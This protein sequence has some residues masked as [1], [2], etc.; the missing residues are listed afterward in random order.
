M[1]ND[2]LEAAVRICEAYIEKVDP[3]QLMGDIPVNSNS[4]A[5]AVGQ[6]LGEMVDAAY[7]ALE[8]IP[9]WAGDEEEEEDEEIRGRRR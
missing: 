8:S 9:E 5:T 3:T 6:K 2:R 7:Q 1:E 4:T